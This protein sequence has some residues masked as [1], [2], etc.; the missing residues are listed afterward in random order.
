MMN[1]RTKQLTTLVM[2][3]NASLERLHAQEAGGELTRDQ[4][5][6]EAKKLIGSLRKDELYF[7]VRGYTDDVNLV[8]PNPKRV[9][10]VD[11]K[12]GKEAG[13]RYR[14]ALAGKT[15]ATLT[16]Y[17]TRPGAKDEVLKLYAITK[18]GPWDW[19]VGFGDYIDDID[20][21]F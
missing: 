7:F 11:S 17:G 16:A 1:E 13:E 9:G 5:Q 6:K 3:A 21:A 2:L 19:I 15:I 18:F 14:A 8:H 12:G 20:T 10:I 4:A